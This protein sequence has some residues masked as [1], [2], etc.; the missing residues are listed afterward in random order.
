MLTKGAQKHGAPLLLFS[1]A[2]EQAR[3]LLEGPVLL[4]GHPPLEALLEERHKLVAHRPVLPARSTF[5]SSSAIFW[6]A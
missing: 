2:P 6:F 5:S 4:C 1:V 3:R